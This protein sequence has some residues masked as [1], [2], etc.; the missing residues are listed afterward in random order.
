MNKPTDE[1]ITSCP[2]GT[3]AVCFQE[4]S[5][6][7]TVVLLGTLGLENAT[8]IIDSVNRIISRDRSKNWKYCVH[9]D[10]RTISSTDAELKFKEFLKF[11]KWLGSLMEHAC[12]VAMVFDGDASHLT[13]TQ[14]ER[15][16]SES[17]IL[18]KSFDDKDEALEWLSIKS[19]EPVE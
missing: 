10:K 18:F 3:Y 9:I 4:H 8:S 1:R 16:F 17:D 6:T 19:N 12:M 14:V 7:V 2:K 13:K 5:N 11:R 15:V